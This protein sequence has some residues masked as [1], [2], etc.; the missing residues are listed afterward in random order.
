[1]H[2][3]LLSPTALRKSAHWPRIIEEVAKGIPCEREQGNILNFIQNVPLQSI[4][5]KEK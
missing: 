5:K 4:I 1:M 3:C 2:A